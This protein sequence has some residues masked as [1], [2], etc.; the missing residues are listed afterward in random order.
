M[1]T[2]E[3]EFIVANQ[4]LDWRSQIVVPNISWGANIHECDLI[5]LNKNGYA[6]GRINNNDR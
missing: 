1:T 4:W 6:T 2:G 5:A 3:I